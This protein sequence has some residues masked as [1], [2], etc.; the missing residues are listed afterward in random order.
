[1]SK[2]TKSESP[3]AQPLGSDA[4]FSIGEHLRTQDNRCAANPS[5]CVQVLERI[6]PIQ[7]EYGSGEVMF[8]DPHQSETYYKDKG[9]TE[10]WKELKALHD[11]YELPDGIEVASYVEVWK[12]V[13]TCFTEN[14]CKRYLELDGHNLRHYYG[15]R[16]Y[17]ESFNRNVE[18][19]EIRKALME[20]R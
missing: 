16:I 15:V 18:M 17:A 6:G 9:D 7:L 12:T 11:D 5:F 2:E 1:M 4:L 19:L 13:Q 14:G 3:P 10:R 8:Y 20:N